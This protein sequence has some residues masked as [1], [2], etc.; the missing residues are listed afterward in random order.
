MVTCSKCSKEIKTKEDLVV[1]PYFLIPKPYHRECY[2]D[3]LTKGLYPPLFK[4]AINVSWL[5]VIAGIG[6]FLILFLAWIF[7]VNSIDLLGNPLI[8]VFTILIF[9]FVFVLSLVERL[10]SYFIFESKLK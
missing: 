5:R 10:Y 4:S 7:I 2:A 6:L 3:I 8:L 9:L 1:A